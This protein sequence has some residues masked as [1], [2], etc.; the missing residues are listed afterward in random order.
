MSKLT[1]EFTPVIDKLADK[2]GL[3]RAAVFGTV[4]RWC[5]MEDRVCKA[6]LTKIAKRLGINKSTLLRHIKVLC[7]DGYLEDLTPDLRNKP[8]TYR[9]TG[10]AGLK[11][12][13]SGFVDDGETVAERNAVLQSATD[14]AETVAEKQLKIQ[15][16]KI[17]KK[18]PKPK[19][20]T[21]PKEWMDAVY[22]ACKMNIST[23]SEA[24]RKTVSGCGLALIK[25]GATIDGLRA[26]YAWH[27]SD[28]WRKDHETLTPKKI[29]DRWGQH[30]GQH[31]EPPVKQ[32]KRKV[33]V[34]R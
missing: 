13:I 19:K 10:K 28:P 9:D 4:W 5:E 31:A 15:D 22:G 6:S 2:Y 1:Q 16:T 25:A 8:H 26:F 33:E 7:E 17:H 14:Q 18:K 20:Q 11:L 27:I 29:R 3:V 23:V 34:F 12:L 24:T 21:C 32:A 30:N